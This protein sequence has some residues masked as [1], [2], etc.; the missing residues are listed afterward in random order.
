MQDKGKIK[1]NNLNWSKIPDHLYRILI[2]WVYGTGKTKALLILMNSET[3]VDEM[4]LYAK[5][6]NLAKYQLLITNGKIWA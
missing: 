2:K 1:Y 5:D 6:P 3:D 4:F